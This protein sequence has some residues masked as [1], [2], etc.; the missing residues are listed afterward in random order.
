M[1]DVK[2]V[3]VF[4]EMGEGVYD[5]ELNVSS[6]SK[7]SIIIEYVKKFIRTHS[8]SSIISCC[9]FSLYRRDIYSKLGF[10]LVE[11]I[12]PRC[13]LY[14]KKSREHIISENNCEDER[15]IPIYDCGLY[16]YQ[17]MGEDV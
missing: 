5:I 9:D 4:R 16:Y 13:H 7:D 2:N 11:C 1:K 10:D 17:Y 3:V 6:N 15:F 14:N 8:F 12:E